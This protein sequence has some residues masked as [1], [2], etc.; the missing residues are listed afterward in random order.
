MLALML[1]F[2]TAARCQTLAD[3]QFTTGTDATKWY[4]IDSAE[5]LLVD[6]SVYYRRTFL[7]DIGFNFPFADTSYSQFSATLHGDLRLGG[8]RALSTG[9]YQGSP[10]HPQRADLNKPKINFFG[11]TG[12][13]SN[14]AYIRCQ[15]FGT[16]PDRVLVIEFA[17]QTYNTTSRNSLYRYQVQLY[18]NGDIQIVYGDI[19]VVNPSGSAAGPPSVQRMQG[20]C[21]GVTDVWTVDT[22]SVATHYT[23]GCS[24]YVPALYWPN[25]YRFYRFSYPND[26]CISPT[27]FNVATIDTS[28]VTLQW[29]NPAYA[30]QFVVEYSN[31]MFAPGTGV[32]TMLTTT[33]TFAVVQGLQAHTQYH[34]F[35]RAICGDDDTSNAAYVSATTLTAEPVSDYPYFCDFESTGERNGWI[36]PAGNLTTRWCTGTAVNNTPQGQYALYVS[37]DSGA[38]N[39]G[40]DDWIGTYAYR[41]LNLEA[42]DWQVSFDWRAYGDW[43]TNSVGTTTF[44]HFLRAF[45]VPSSVTFNAQTPPS[46][47]SSATHGTAVPTGWIELNPTTHSFVNQ[48]TW[49]SYTTTATVLQSG[50]YHLVFYWETDGYDPP[51]D[52]PAAIDNVSV[53]HIDC[54]QPYAISAVTSENEILLSWR[55]GGN[56]NLWMV[57]YGTTEAYVMDTFYLASGLDFNTLYTFDVYAVCGQGDTSF[58]TTASFRT[59]AGGPV[60][61]YPYYCDFEDSLMARQWVTLGEGQPN[62]WYVGTAVN[63][64]P[65]GQKSLYVSQDG[66]TTNTYTGTTRALSYAYRM[67]V[68]DTIDYVCTFDWRCLGDDDFH[69]LRAF[70]VRADAIPTAGTFPVNTTYHHN[71]VPTG[72][73]DLNTTNHYMSGQNSWTTQTQTFSVP[74]SGEYALM[75]MWEND[76][77]TPN[78][79]PAAVDNISI[80]IIH[81]PIPTGLA[82][83]PLTTMIDLTWNAGDDAQIWLVEYADTS[84]MTYTPSY[85]AMGLTPNT[86]YHFSVSTLCYSGDTSLAATLT[87][88]TACEPITTLP[89][90]CDFDDY[91]TGM[92]SDEAF[93]PCWN[94]VRNY[95]TFSPKISSDFTSGDNC[96]YWN[97]TAGLLDDAIAVLP[98]LDESIEVTYTELSFKA[99]KQDYFGMYEDPVLIIGVMSDPTSAASFSSVDT[100]VVTSTTGFVEYSV[101][102]LSYV[103]S[104]QYVA[105]RCIV[106][107]SNYASTACLIDDID[108]HELQY[109]RKPTAMSAETGEDTIAVSWTPG[110]N[111]M[112]WILSYSDTVVTTLQPNYIARNLQP[113]AEYLFSVVSVCAF[114]DTSDVLSGRFRTLPHHVDPPEPPDTVD[115]PDVTDLNYTQETPWSDHAYE[116]TFHWSGSA[117]AYEIRI[118]NLSEPEWTPLVATVTTT[119]YFFNAEGVSGEWIAAVRSVCEDG[120]Y[121]EWSDTLVFDTP[122]C[123]GV[124]TPTDGDG[125]SLYPNPSNGRATL[126]LN[127]LN[128]RVGVSVV[129]LSGRILMSTDVNCDNGVSLP[130]DG[131][132]PGTY[133]V[134]VSAP[135]ANAVRKLIVK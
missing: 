54:A 79:P 5:N 93:I 116:F 71:T 88:R 32:G 48:S 108:L 34:F 120:V 8:T 95:S 74:D 22:G 12:Y 104:D 110:G 35:V 40:G 24:F 59:A 17:L 78:N 47:P 123:I 53:E 77:Y 73:I 1:A 96:L 80:D 83:D 125:I 14:S 33:D 51:T 128:G 82:G 69:Y 20:L 57:R 89:Y 75:F 113:D 30:S 64:T 115:C 39:T 43:S 66:G 94:R 112:Q 81:C 3:Y 117:S 97:L 86:E 4:T 76:D 91:P 135:N 92:G 133:F 28:S 25:Q 16:A 131:L 109:C 134:R 119:D 65:Q 55:R 85:T 7:V 11:C 45:L 105:I 10:F 13:A 15:L 124:D 41:D 67:L 19:D 84:A 106:S 122:L 52:M 70:I 68:L 26:V 46:F 42:G 9:N 107:G 98:E 101:P 99:K 49:A 60:T 36:I 127:G 50:C 18:E 37:Q 62:Q 23:N 63:N 129:D 126:S 103:G 6:G 27:H 44:Y 118:E 100:I 38:T 87:M 130:I 132:A 102:M 58:A 2:G 31:S 90:L 61:A 111:E 21:D 121:G 72:W 29:D 114:G 56:E